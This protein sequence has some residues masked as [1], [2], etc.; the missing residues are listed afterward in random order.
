MGWKKYFLLALIIL[1]LTISKSYGV[2]YQ[3][4]LLGS[5]AIA[6]T[7]NDRKAEA[8]RLLEQ[9]NKQFEMSQFKE[10]LQSWEQSLAIYREIGDRQGEATSLLRLGNVYDSQEDYG[11]A[12]DYYL[13]SL[14]IFKQ[15]GNSQGEGASLENLGS[16]YD[17]WGDYGKA[18]DYH[19]QSL[20]I[21]KKIGDR[22][23]EATSLGNLGI[24]YNRLGYYRRA[25][26]YHL[27]SLAIS[28]KIG[29][30]RGEAASLGGLGNAYDN[31]GYYREAIDHH[32]QCLAIFKKI[33]NPQSEAASL[34]NLGNVYD[35]LG[36]Y[37]EAIDY[38]LQSLAI[39]KKIGNRRGEAAS[40]GGLGNAYHSLGDYHEAIN[41]HLQSL[42]IKKK[43]GDRRGE[44]A[45]LGNLGNAYNNLRG[46][47]EAID[48][49]LQSLAIS[50]KIGDRRGE[51]TS[52]GNLGNVYD[53]L[54]DYRKAIDY[55]R[56][57]LAIEKKLGNRQGQ[58]ASWNNLG[59]TL[60]KY[61]KLAAAE[62]NLRQAIETWENIRQDLGNKDTWKVSI[63]EEQ[64][65]TYSLL[66][67]VLVAQKKPQEALV[68]SEQGRTRALVEILLRRISQKTDVQ[69]IPVN[70]N[71]AEIKQIAQKQNATLVE[72]SIVFD[73]QLYIWVIPPQGEVQFRPVNLP[74]DISLQE[75]VKLS[76]ESI[77]A[78]GRDSDDKSTSQEAN[79]QNRLQQLHQLLIKPIAGLLPQDEKQR[80][81]F[82]PHQELF[83]VPFVALQD[84]K[85]QYL[86]EKHT[87]LTAPSIQ[88]LSLTP[89]DKQAENNQNTSVL[90][91]GESALIVGN[92]TMPKEGVGK[93]LKPLDPLPG[94]KVEAEKIAEM[95]DTKALIGDQATESVIVEKMASAKLIHFATHGLLDSIN[96][97]GSPGAIALAPSS[98]DDGFLTTSEIME[99]FGLPEKSPL[100]AELV[101]LSACDTGR[102][103]IRGEGV[104]GLSRAFMASGVPT[105]VV[106]LWTVP[107]GD[108]VKLMTD[109]Y[110]NIDK[111]KFD[112]A[113]AMRQAM[114][115]MLK[116]D[117]G[118]PDPKAWAAFTVIGKAE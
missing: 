8:D 29:N 102:G 83:L 46:Y 33:G 103:D 52:L 60:R 88:A 42:A 36:D 78:K 22:R 90:P 99:Y 55:H 77:G 109:F 10:A 19:L 95:L 112:K 3:V 86:I 34:G 87:I 32:L 43:I 15:I 9:G 6:Q 58:A 5:T 7:T 39:S 17:G 97:I 20:A 40:L 117:D 18:I 107:D 51:A 57:S 37:H 27:Q 30:R 62:N 94:A 108:T 67:Q 48:Y 13:R 104:I 80:V 93:D 70:L 91:R 1:S 61:G 100:Q 23:G 45:S 89:K 64:A 41:Y 50:K 35:S 49:H 116:D 82:I 81:I 68:I 38:H 74:K 92:P 25:I 65:R 14:A 53:S 105:L 44:A 111:H 56:R 71:L 63:F 79:S 4:K 114:L 101:V 73:N 28:K 115:S 106:S 84:D 16:A 98:K 54:G 47:H 75:L 11:K 31:L 2:N 113:T 96:A 21:S 72:Y 118:N 66:Q 110:T 59:E 76:R 24:I 12:I 85:N 69:L 26:D